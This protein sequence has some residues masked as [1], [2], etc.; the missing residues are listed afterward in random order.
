MASAA[1][2]AYT[3]A[4]GGGLLAVA[5]AASP[6]GPNQARAQRGSSATP[7]PASV[8]EQG[9]AQ[10]GS[11]ERFLAMMA[12][13]VCLAERSEVFTAAHDPGGTSTR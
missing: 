10:R 13:H 8:Y 7:S 5:S 9:R 11:W 2:L 6:R 1:S 12:R 4:A 3:K